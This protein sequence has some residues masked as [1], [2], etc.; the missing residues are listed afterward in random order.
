MTSPSLPAALAAILAL[1]ACAPIGVALGGGA[2]VTRS[3]LQERS[4]ADLLT[5]KEIDI[6]IQSKLAGHSTG[7]FADVFV[8]VVEGR[9]LIT[10]S[11]PSREEKIEA[12]RLAWTVPGVATVQDELAV[13]EDAGTGAYLDDVW[14]SNRL[15]YEL[16]TDAA[17]RSVNYNVTTVDRVVHLTGLARSRA[18]LVRVIDHAALVPGAAEVVSH[19][20][21]I[22]D[23]RRAGLPA[24]DA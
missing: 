11:V 16:T 3:V 5:D 4:T 21:V 14:I 9:V 10:G 23:P 6:R 7:L 18:E 8:D 2:V 12:T 22:D 17:V 19:V 13:A 15:R 1:S 20:L 24:D